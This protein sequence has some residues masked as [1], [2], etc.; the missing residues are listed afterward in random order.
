MPV[1]R[2]SVRG[3]HLKAA[4]LALT[5]SEWISGSCVVSW[6]VRGQIRTQADLFKPKH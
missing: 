4:M 5:L 1:N 2:L 6:R 3:R